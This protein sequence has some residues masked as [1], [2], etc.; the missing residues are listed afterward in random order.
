LRVQGGNGIGNG[1]GF[2]VVA[3][4]GDSDFAGGG[5]AVNA[6]GGMSDS[7]A[8]GEAVHALGGFSPNGSGGDGLVAIGGNSGGQGFSAGNGI[9]AIQGEG[10]SGAADGLAGK[11]DGDVE[12]NGNLDV[13]GTKNFKI[14]HP[15]DPENK[16]LIH[17]AIESSEVLN[18]YSGNVTTNQQ[19]EAVV[20]LPDWFEALNKDL[21]YQL[22]VI[23]TFAQAIVAEKVR[24]NRFIIRTSAPSVEVSWQVT[25]VRSDAAMRK[26]AFKAEQEKP[27]RERGTYLNPEAYGQVE[28]RGIEWARHPELMRQMKARRESLRRNMP[29]NHH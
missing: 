12:I 5:V 8:A 15:L 16:Y 13:S 10:G 2:A 26:H 23:G 25:G 29:V 1:A 27:A 4:G 24:G 22:T 14:D 17:A 7:S 18:V 19:G 9:F 28:E 6:I 11:F 3:I 21:R 20:A